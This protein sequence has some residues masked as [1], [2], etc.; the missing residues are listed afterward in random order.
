M[1][2]EDNKI[3][4]NG[5][6]AP[7]LTW[8]H[9]EYF[10]PPRR[11]LVAADHLD[12]A[13][14]ANVYA[15]DPTQAPHVITDKGAWKYCA[16]IPQWDF[17]SVCSYIAKKVGGRVVADNDFLYYDGNG[18]D[19]KNTTRNIIANKVC[20]YPK[21]HDISKEVS[22]ACIAY[23]EVGVKDVDALITEIRRYHEAMNERATQIELAEWLSKGN[24]MMRHKDDDTCFTGH[25]PTLGQCNTPVAKD[26][27]IYS[28]EAREWVEPTLVNMKMERR[29]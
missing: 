18:R 11:M 5:L 9:R 7:I 25:T 14:V 24:G 17:N 22:D 1:L 19:D 16:D 21:W 27:R 6:K 13:K 4:Y 15:Y 28:W 20:I 3:N 8:D 29:K 10:D 12:C 23:D 26:I 2:V